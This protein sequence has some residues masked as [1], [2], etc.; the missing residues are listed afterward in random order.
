MPKSPED[1]GS[2]LSQFDEVAMPRR[3]DLLRG[4]VIA[5]NPQGLVVDLA[6]KRDGVVPRSDL[7]KLPP[8]EACQK[9]GDEV[10]VMVVDPVDVDGSLLVSISQ[11][12]E[13][14]DWLKARSLLDE[15]AIIE[16]AP[17]GCN[18]GGIIVPFG[19]L[20]GFVPASHLSE[21]PRGIDE[22]GRMAFL[23]GSIGRKMPFK[24]IEVD[25]KRRRLVLSERK[26]IRQWRQQ[27]KSK[28]IETL[29]V[30][31]VRKGVVTSLREFGAFV[32]IGG[33]DGLIHI[34]EI[35]WCHVED[36]SDVLTI[37]QEIETMV[38]GLDKRAVRISLSLKRLEPN[39][40]D[41]CGKDISAGQVLQ[42][43][44]SCNSSAGT[45]VQVFGGIEGLLRLAKGA[46]IP[47]KGDTIQVRVASLD[48]DRERLDLELVEV[49]AE[50]SIEETNL[51]ANGL[52]TMED[53]R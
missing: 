50:I 26:A 45:F 42:G 24:V 28:I 4:V 47:H 17:C 36:P 30:G 53:G 41:E 33:A 10:A 2:L 11:A 27:Q 40:W 48:L 21:L 20:R 6:L 8:E 1:L 35:A 7:D 39:P 19:R 32:D 23:E 34:S 3:G 13:S 25:P 52:D 22:A 14:E 16:V 37:D 38:I 51:P 49:E 5:S 18:R 12:R 9:I 29:Q 44:V 15:D 43:V 31:E 46:L